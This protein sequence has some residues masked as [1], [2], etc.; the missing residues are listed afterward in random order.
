M[1]LA[2]VADVLDCASIPFFS[3]ASE[4]P[5]P[6]LLADI[7]ARTIAVRKKFLRNTSRLRPS[8]LETVRLL[9]GTYATILRGRQVL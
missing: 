5:R 3:G 6:G 7:Q 9:K 2:V 1:H 8:S 4:L